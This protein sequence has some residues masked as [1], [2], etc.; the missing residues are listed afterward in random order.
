MRT[1]EAITVEVAEGSR[2]GRV[3]GQKEYCIAISPI[4]R[5]RAGTFAA[6]C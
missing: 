6:Q 5:F 1:T 2:G 3:R 4:G